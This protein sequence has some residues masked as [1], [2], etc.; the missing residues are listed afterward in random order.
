MTVTQLENWL[1]ETFLYRKNRFLPGERGATGNPS[2][3]LYK[4][5]RRKERRSVIIIQD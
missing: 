3:G 2:E 5:E 4:N 1:L